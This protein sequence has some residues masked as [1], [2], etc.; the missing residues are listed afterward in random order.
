MRIEGVYSIWDR[1]AQVSLPV[2]SSRDDVTASRTFI[3]AVMTS[4]TPVAQYPADFDL[5]KL[6]NIDLDTGQLSPIY[7][8]DILVNGL[9]ALQD[10]HRTRARYQAM[11]QPSEAP[12]TSPEAS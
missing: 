9:V 1:K 12:E 11:L 7:P 5:I 3:E 2:F 4:E 6:G 8:F 10:A